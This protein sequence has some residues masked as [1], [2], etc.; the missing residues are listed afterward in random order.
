MSCQVIINPGRKYLV[1]SIK[2]SVQMLTHKKVELI[3]YEAEILRLLSL[4]LIASTDEYFK[5][6]QI[7]GNWLSISLL[8]IT[9]TQT[10]LWNSR[11]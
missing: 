1:R 10:A 11:T 9:Q 2:L 3:F 8:R 4:P 6:A 7:L 5:N